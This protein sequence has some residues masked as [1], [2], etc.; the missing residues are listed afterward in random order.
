[1]MLMCVLVVTALFVSDV[2][3]TH[4]SL[5]L[6]RTQRHL[7]KREISRGPCDE[8]WFYFP[9][10]NSCYRF[11]SDKM[12]WEQAEDFCNQVVCCGQLASVNS[13]KHNTFISN[14]ISIMDQKKPK[15]WI[16]LNDICQDGN[17]T[18]IDGLSYSYKR[19]GTGEPNNY[20]GREDCVNIHHFPDTTWNDESCKLTI[21]FVCSYKLC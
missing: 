16:G 3:G 18:W 17:F 6:E 14:V 5:E 1:M 15:A 11:F 9:P 2:T 8:K 20:G 4:N 7:E 12:T 19:F 10:L 13:D 21:G